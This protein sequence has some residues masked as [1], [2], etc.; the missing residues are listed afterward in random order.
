MHEV[1]LQG[2]G[3]GLHRF[4]SCY[5]VWLIDIEHRRF[6]RLRY[7]EAHTP[8]SNWARYYDLELDLARGGFAITLNEEGTV[9]LRA[10]SHMEPCRFCTRGVVH[11]DRNGRVKHGHPSPPVFSDGVGPLS[12]DWAWSSES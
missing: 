3:C 7:R 12:E 2:D 10:W 11:P 9:V 6:C 4:E 1:D 5:G 8:T